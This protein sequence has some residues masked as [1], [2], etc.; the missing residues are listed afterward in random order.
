MRKI[1]ITL[2]ITFV[3]T[4][5]HI[6]PVMAEDGL[7]LMRVTCYCPES[8]PG[9]RTASG[10][11]PIPNYTCGARSDLIGSVAM[12][13]EQNADGT[14]GEFVGLYEVQDT[15]SAKRIQSGKSIDIYQANLTDAKAFVKAHGD[16]L[17]VQIIKGKG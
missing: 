17:Y 14:I 13:Y 12:V 4:L 8:C 16:Y 7:Q 10:T 9:T 5:F 2:F 3:M 6:M 15:G 1:V 11:V